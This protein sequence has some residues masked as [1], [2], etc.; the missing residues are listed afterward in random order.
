MVCL[1]IQSHYT[2]NQA[3]WISSCPCMSHFDNDNWQFLMTMTMMSCFGNQSWGC[4][5]NWTKVT[6]WITEFYLVFRELR[7]AGWWSPVNPMVQSRWNSLHLQTWGQPAK[8]WKP[9][10]EVQPEYQ[11]KG[12]V[13]GVR[14]EPWVVYNQKKDQYECISYG[15]L[16]FG[17]SKTPISPIMFA[18]LHHCL[19]HL[20]TLAT[21]FEIENK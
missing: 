18:S 7:M 20:A 21:W 14:G 10:Q 2:T 11:K 3:A 6:K 17:C 4:L 9:H 19:N 16:S 8:G 12:I 5:T 15:T 13:Q 1:T